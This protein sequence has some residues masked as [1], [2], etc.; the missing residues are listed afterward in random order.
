ME[1]KGYAILGGAADIHAQDDLACE[2][3]NLDVIDYLVNNGANIH[4][5]NNQALDWA[6]KHGNTHIVKYLEDYIEKK[7]EIE[8][9]QKQL[10]DIQNK[11]NVLMKTQ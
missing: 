4:A 3:G 5:K 1:P 11:L 8:E 6:S 7:K 10:I 2:H 9:L